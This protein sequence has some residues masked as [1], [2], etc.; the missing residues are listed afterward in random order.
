MDFIEL[1]LDEIPPVMYGSVEID[2]N[3]YPVIEQLCEAVGGVMSYTSRLIES[4][5]NTV[6]VTAEEQSPFCRIF[7]YP[8][9]LR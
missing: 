1:S 6:G 3:G 2:P 8:I 7:S 4:L 5:L 9:D